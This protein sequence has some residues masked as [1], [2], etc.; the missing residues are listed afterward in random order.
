MSVRRRAPRRD[1]NEREIIDT[2]RAVG[3]TVQQ[4]SA[5]GVPDLLV[6]FD[7]ENYLL[8]VKAVKYGKLTEDEAA[9]HEA[10]AGSVQVVRTP[11]EAL[12]AIGLRG[13]Q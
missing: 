7:G 9:W 6:G 10:W 11:D 5:K 12:R 8:E 1:N 2:L 3:A 13:C 4:L